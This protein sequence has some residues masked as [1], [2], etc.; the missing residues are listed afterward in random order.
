METC[1]TEAQRENLRRV[2]WE[3]HV[4]A[5]GLEMARINF[6]P[7]KER[8]QALYEMWEHAR[9]KGFRSRQERNP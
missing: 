9:D 4:R 2:E 5:F 8:R 1:L 6:L 7:E 3:F